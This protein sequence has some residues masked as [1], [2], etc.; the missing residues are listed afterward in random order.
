MAVRIDLKECINCSWC[1]RACPTEC[2]RYFSTG[3]RTHIVDPDWCIDC[4]ICVN[5][6]P[7]GCID[8]DPYRPQPDQLERG[9]EKARAWAARQRALKLARK[10]QVAAALA[11][12]RGTP[13][14]ATRG[15]TP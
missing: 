2:I 15:G 1:R 6:C 3:R 13:A 11:R 5:V 10:A 12:V 4:K 8:D 9:K 14:L 7:V